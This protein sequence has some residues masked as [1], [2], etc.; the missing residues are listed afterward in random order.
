MKYLSFVGAKPRWVHS[1]RTQRS[2]V[3]GRRL[4]PGISSSLHRSV[5]AVVWV[6]EAPCGLHSASPLQFVTVSLVFCLP[7][8][9]PIRG[10]WQTC[11]GSRTGPP[12]WSGCSLTLERRNAHTWRQRAAVVLRKKIQT[13]KTQINSGYLQNVFLVTLSCTVLLSWSCML[14][15]SGLDWCLLVCEAKPVC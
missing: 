15:L 11:G 5:V 7:T 9:G 2:W 13:R 8:A 12:S 14:Y 3:V 4:G 6:N 1:N 10:G